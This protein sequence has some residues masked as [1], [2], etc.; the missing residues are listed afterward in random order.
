MEEVDIIS[1][2]SERQEAK[3]QKRQYFVKVPELWQ[4]RPKAR[5]SDA[6]QQL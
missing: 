4:T 6:Q 5:L 2:L 3:A 1:L